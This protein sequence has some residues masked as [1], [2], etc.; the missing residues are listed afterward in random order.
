MLLA[1]EGCQVLVVINQPLNLS[2]RIG[3]YKVSQLRS[4]CTG[5][6]LLRFSDLLWGCVPC[7]LALVLFSLDM[8]LSVSV[9]TKHQT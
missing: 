5:K 3:I 6:V 2:R 9:I 4:F 7:D 1:E 8:D